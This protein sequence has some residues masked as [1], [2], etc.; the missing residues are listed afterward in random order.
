M[1]RWGLVF[2]LQMKDLYFKTFHCKVIYEA[3]RDDRETRESKN[4]NNLNQQ[5][6]KALKGHRIWQQFM[7]AELF[8]WLRRII[9]QV[10]NTFEEA[11]ISLWKSTIKKT[12]SWRELQGVYNEVNQWLHSQEVDFNRK[13]VKESTQL[14]K[15]QKQT[16]IGLKKINWRSTCIRI[17]GRKTYWEE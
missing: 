4:F 6:L 3:Q 9:D 12:P 10:K 5:G 8:P 17:I 11:G 13:H 15:K 16:N 1:A 7:M 14:Q 2:S